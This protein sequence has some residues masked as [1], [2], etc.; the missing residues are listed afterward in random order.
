[1]YLDTFY[2]PI[3]REEDMIEKKLYEKDGF[4]DDIYPCRIFAENEFHKINFSAITIF[5]GGNGGAVFRL[6][7]HHRD[8]LA[9]LVGTGRNRNLRSRRDA[10]RHQKLVGIGKH[11]N[12]LRIFQ[13]T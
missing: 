2:L 1:M 10:G 4:L 5:Y 12:L 3:D 13:N 6:P 11:K 8:A 9:F 7:I